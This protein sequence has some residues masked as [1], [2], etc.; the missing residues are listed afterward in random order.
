MPVPGEVGGVKARGVPSALPSCKARP[1]EQ[2]IPTAHGHQEVLVQGKR[3]WGRVWGGEEAF[4]LPE[5]YL[6]CFPSTAIISR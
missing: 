6:P 2:L 5:V 3:A 1:G 4:S